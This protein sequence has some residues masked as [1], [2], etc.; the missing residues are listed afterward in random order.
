[1]TGRIAFAVIMLIA[2]LIPDMDSAS[3]LI[4]RKIRPFDMIFNFLFKH[5]GA[6]HSIT[7]C[8][9]LTIILALFSQ[10]LALPFFLG[11]AIHLLADSF[12]ITGIRAFWPSKKEIKWII[13]TG[14]LTEK[15]IFYLLIL[16]NILVIVSL[17]R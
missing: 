1:V 14:G 2:T 17:I 10:K 12:T 9:I 3:S 4:N 11:Y 5:R 6:L 13:R 15:I 8:I 16:T 7:F